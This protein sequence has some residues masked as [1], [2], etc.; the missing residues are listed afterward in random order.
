MYLL[1]VTHACSVCG[2]AMAA[3]GTHFLICGALWHT[4]VARHNALTEARL[5]IAA[6]GGIAATREPHVKQLPQRPRATGLPALPTRP[7]PAPSAGS[8]CASGDEASEV[9]ENKSRHDT[10]VACRR[11]S[12]STW[13]GQLLTKHAN[14]SE[15]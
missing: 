1:R 5:R 3:G 6:R 15:Q 14:T 8:T 4:V 12:G 9:T 11:R 2:R 13:R 7:P 10:L